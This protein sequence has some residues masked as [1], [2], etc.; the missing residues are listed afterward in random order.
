MTK[1]YQV[2]QRVGYHETPLSPVL[3]D[4]VEATKVRAMYEQL[5]RE[6]PGCYGK[7]ILRVT[8]F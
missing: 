6:N 4:R 2:I 5:S 3:T 1:N 7:I 8:Q